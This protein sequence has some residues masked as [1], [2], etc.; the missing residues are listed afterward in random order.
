[1]QH[2][3]TEE[4][5]LQALADVVATLPLE[6][7]LAGLTLEERL[8]GLTPAERERLRQLLQQPEPK[9]GEDSNPK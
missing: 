2:Y 3:G 8:Q 1:M 6:K 4:E 7:R 9:E 5:M